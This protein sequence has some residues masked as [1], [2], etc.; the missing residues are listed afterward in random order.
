MN[1]KKVALKLVAVFEILCGWVGIVMVLEGILG[2]LPYEAVTSL[3]FGIFPI[4]SLAAGVMI[5]LRSKYALPLS[6]LVLVLQIPYIYVSGYSLMRFG[7]AFNLNVTAVWNARAGANATV[8]GINFLALGML[9]V[10]LWSRN[11]M[12]NGFDKDDLSN[13]IENQ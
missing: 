13:S 3:W 2:I 12:E 4:L 5:W 1:M 11:A 10:L 8:L 6:F 7:L 9:F